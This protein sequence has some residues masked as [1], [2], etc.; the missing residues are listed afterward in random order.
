MAIPAQIRKQSEAVAKLYEEL[1]P[2]DEG[3]SPAEGEAQQPTEANGEGG[4]AA[5]SAPAEQG[6]T[7]T[8]NDNPTAEQR[9]RTL[10][11]MYNADTAR[12]R[13]ENNQMGQRVTQLEQLI[14]SAWEHVVLPRVLRKSAYPEDIVDATVLRPVL[15]VACVLH[16]ARQERSVGADYVARWSEEFDRLLDN[17]M[18]RI[19]LLLADWVVS[20]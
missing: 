11:G 18:G 2:T 9:Y 12:L 8:T 7:G 3:Q 14:A 20:H 6:R 19:K 13:A 15:A 16:A 10:Q 4:S 5:E 17:T 1:N